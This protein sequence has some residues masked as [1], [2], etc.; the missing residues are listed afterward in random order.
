[1]DEFLAVLFESCDG[2]ECEFV[3]LRD[4]SGR[5]WDGHGSESFIGL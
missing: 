4:L 2:I 3:I 1:M 5:A